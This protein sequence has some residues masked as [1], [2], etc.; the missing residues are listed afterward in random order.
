MKKLLAIL[1]SA[2]LLVG[3]QNNNGTTDQ[4]GVQKEFVNTVEV[5]T[6]PFDTTDYPFFKDGV[7]MAIE[8][9][10]YEDTMRMLDEGGT[11]IIIFGYAG[12]GYCQRALPVLND[13]SLN[14]GVKAYYCDIVA[15]ELGD[16]E[17]AN[18]IS[19]LESILKVENGE[20]VM[21]VPEVI[22]IKDGEIVGHQLSFDCAGNELTQEERDNLQAIYEGL[23]EK[24]Y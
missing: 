22:A 6:I 2:L 20:P 3:C 7:D 9:I 18:V 15:E 11:G 10:S 24:L 5:N 1:M 13:A 14:K 19:H 17:F 4:Q 8:K 12:C 21:Y 23:I 16:E